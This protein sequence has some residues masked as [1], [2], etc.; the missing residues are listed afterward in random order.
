MPINHTRLWTSWGQGPKGLLLLSNQPLS[1]CLLNKHTIAICWVKRIPDIPDFITLG[2]LLTPNLD[3]LIPLDLSVD[4]AQWADSNIE[5]KQ[6]QCLRQHHSQFLPET[7][8]NLERQLWSFFPCLTV[9]QSVMFSSLKEMYKKRHVPYS[10]CSMSGRHPLAQLQ[11]EE[12][13]RHPGAPG[14][15]LRPSVQA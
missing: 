3:S 11:A 4:L 2:I 10:I 1:M 13:P 6:L 5:S 8:P 7:F 15:F 9:W 12:T 14:Q